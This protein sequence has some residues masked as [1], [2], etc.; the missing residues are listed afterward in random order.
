MEKKD[1]AD[2]WAPHVSTPYQHTGMDV[3][4]FRLAL[5]SEHILRI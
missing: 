2:I 1:E 4:L 5:R 3:D